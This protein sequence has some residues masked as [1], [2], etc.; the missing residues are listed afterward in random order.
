MLASDKV[1]SVA[2]IAPGARE[3]AD[4]DMA[5]IFTRLTTKACLAESNALI[6]ADP[7]G[8]SFA[9]AGEAMGRI[10]MTELL[11][12]PATNAAFGSYT[13]YLDEKAFA[14][15]APPK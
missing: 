11:S 10:A 13:K 9:V 12:D 5:A 8:S 3:Q 14:A 15:F 4:R 7:S 2:Q 6:K 1:R